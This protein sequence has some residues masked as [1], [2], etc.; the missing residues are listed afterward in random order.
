M[1][2]Q[3]TYSVKIFWVT[4]PQT[5]M[6]C[7]LIVFHTMTFAVTLSKDL[8]HYYYIPQASTILSTC[9][10]SIPSYKFTIQAL[11]DCIH[12]EQ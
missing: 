11:V 5:P 3:S 1:Q 12:G 4:R 7:M 6:L 10:V 8:V 9:T 2:S